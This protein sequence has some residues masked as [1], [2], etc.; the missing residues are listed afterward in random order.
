MIPILILL[1]VLAGGAPAMGQ[2]PALLPSSPAPANKPA[3]TSVSPSQAQQTVEVLKDEKKRAALIST[4]ETIAH[5]Q[6]PPAAAALPVPLEP[7]GLAAQ[8]LFGLTDFFDHL[9]SESRAAVEAFEHSPQVWHGFTEIMDNPGEQHQ[10]FDAIWRFAVIMG[11]GVA[12]EWAV[13][14]A[15]RVP[16]RR[17]WGIAPGGAHEADGFEEEETGEGE[18]TVSEP[19]DNAADARIAARRRR[20]A[21][22]WTFLRR[23]PSRLRGLRSTSCR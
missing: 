15:L 13:R 22:A 16:H 14:R 18:P 5:A 11:A 9:S 23:L 4:L 1:L 17:L 7:N 20:R 6:P 21:S 8:A 2:T 3:A 19:D 10:L 12:T